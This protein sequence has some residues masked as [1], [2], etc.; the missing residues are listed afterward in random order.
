MGLGD[1]TRVHL[2]SFKRQKQKVKLLLGRS[3]ESR[4]LEDRP[5]E[6]FHFVR[7]I[8]ESI[9]ETALFTMPRF[10]SLVVKA[11][12]G[13]EWKRVPFNNEDLSFDDLIIMLQR[14]FHL[15][16]TEDIRL[17]YQDEGECKLG[18]NQPKIKPFLCFILTFF[19]Y[20]YF[21]GSLY[22]DGDLVTLESSQDVAH[23]IQQ[24]N[25]LRIVI[26]SMLASPKN[27]TFSQP[28]S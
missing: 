13:S 11:R 26:Y 19:L 24:N 23:A 20:H 14:V 6:P 22:A 1:E 16:S 12:L 8:I 18:R 3:I 21:D 27:S 5:F 25:V 4:R 15:S 9:V 10:T 2:N 17:K 28:A 7:K